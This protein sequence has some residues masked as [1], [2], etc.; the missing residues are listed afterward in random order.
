MRSQGHIRR[1]DHAEQLPA[2][3]TQKSGPRHASATAVMRTRAPGR[4]TDR[5]SLA[6]FTVKKKF[7]SLGCY[8]SGPPLP[9]LPSPH[10]FL[11]NVE[12]RPYFRYLLSYSSYPGDVRIPFVY[13]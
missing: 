9:N 10:S 6:L 7:T 11:F 8:F 3:C 12:P 2:T 5:N 13:F 4:S 1:Y